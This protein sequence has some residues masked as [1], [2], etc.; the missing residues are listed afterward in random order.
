MSPMARGSNQSMKRIFFLALAAVLSACAQTPRTQMKADFKRSTGELEAAI[1]ARPKVAP[2]DAVSQALLPPLVVEMPKVDGKPV[3]ARFDLAVN[4][5]PAAEVFMAIVSGT[6]YSMVVHPSIKE[7]IS[8]NLK[9]VTVTEALETIRDMYGY[10]YK[11]QGTRILIQPVALQTRVFMVNYL[12]SNR[13]GQSNVRVSSGAISDAA[14]P[15]QAGAPTAITVP[16]GVQV[17]AL[18]SARIET[19]AETDFWNDLLNAVRTL[20]GSEAGRNVIVNP[21]SG[22]VVVRAMPAELRSVDEYLRQIEGMVVRQ[23]LLEAKIIEVQLNDRYATGINWAAFRSGDN[24]RF[25][26]GIIT[27]GATLQPTG[28]VQAFTARGPDGQVLPS[29]DIT[30]LPGAPGNLT[31]GFGLPGTVLG[32]A[33]QTSNFAALLGFLET[34]GNLQVL[35]SPRIATLNNQKAVL[36]VGT[37]E[38]FVTNVTTNQTTTTGGVIQNSPTITVQPFFSGVSLDVTPQIDERTSQV[39]LHVHPSVSKVIDKTKD[40]SLGQA[41]NFR[42]PLASSDVRETDTIVKVNDGNIVAIG[43][44]MREQQERN[45]AGLPVAGD[46]PVIGHLFKNTNRETVKSELVILIKP[47][48]IRTEDTWKQDL[49]DTRDRIENLQHQDLSGWREPFAGGDASASKPVQ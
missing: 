46:I 9:D 10:E 8:V 39:I 36:K 37:D 44:L 5:A 35:S 11:I 38:F 29:S 20:V 31:A 30:S 12:L 16:Q 47:T 45:K 6:R 23:V 48:I 28:T 17:R 19:R 33:F 1:A 27:P 49:Q 2:P 3:D 40:L 13:K 7:K 32:I 14:G 43:G 24:T 15:T 34:Q 41:G 42:L 21:Q 25:A 4:N 18:E 22:L 26:G